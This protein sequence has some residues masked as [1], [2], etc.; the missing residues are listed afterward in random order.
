MVAPLRRVAVRG[1]CPGDHVAAGWRR[2]PDAGRAREQH[3][4]FVEVLR[5]AGAQVDLLPGADDLPDACFT[6]DPVL[7]A[8]GGMVVLRQA[9]PAR[10]AEPGLL[11]GE[12]AT[13]GVPLLGRLEGD[14]HADA[15]D[16][17]WLDDQTL[18]A[19]RGYRTD[20]AA[21]EQ[22]RALLAG[23]GVEVLGFDLPH[24][25]GPDHVLHLMSFVSLVSHD[26]AVVFEPLA[27]VAFLDALRERGMRWVAA[28]R[29]EYDA[30]GT[31]VLALAPGRVVM[32]EGAPVVAAGLRD[33]GVEVTE[34]DMSE[35]A[36]GDGGPT[37]LTRPLLRG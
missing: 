12:L 28:S 20:A 35:F 3:S 37:C 1:L 4:A 11:G 5:D 25:R 15:G 18:A 31:N 27:P 22:L 34:L 13:L 23:Q 14:A 17:L 26:L 29:E 36:A 33:A 21:H 6:Y 8:G 32:F 9:K 7:V 16:L 10:V 2:P 19:G 24:D 30:L